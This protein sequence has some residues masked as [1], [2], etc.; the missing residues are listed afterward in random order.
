MK[1]FVLILT[2]LLFTL[3]GCN[4]AEQARTDD[5]PEPAGG[6]IEID[7]GTVGNVGNISIGLGD[8]G[9]S[10]YVD[11]NGVEQKGLV[12]SLVLYDRTDE[13]E[14]SITAYPGKSFEFH[15]YTFYV[16]EIK[17]TRLFPW[18]PPGATGGGS[19]SLIVSSE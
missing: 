6:M 3:T 12:A 18:S 5:L 8:T 10:E 1:V 4:Y 11:D 7:R 14:K 19:I 16:K 2:V 9:T 13:S 17:A 15:G